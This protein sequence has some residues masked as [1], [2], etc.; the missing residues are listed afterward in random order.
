MPSITKVWL[1]SSDDPLVK[2]LKFQFLEK[3]LAVQ[4]VLSSEDFIHP[5]EPNVSLPVHGTA[6]L[7][8]AQYRG[9]CVRMRGIV[10]PKLHDG[11]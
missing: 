10:S 4:L 11:T 3:E 1:G 6:G 8:Y 5:L 9:G 2:I 7:I